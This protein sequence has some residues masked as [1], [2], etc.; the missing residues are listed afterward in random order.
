MTAAGATLALPDHL[1]ATFGQRHSP[2]ADFAARWRTVVEEQSRTL[3]EVKSI[4]RPRDLMA[5]LA[6]RG[7]DWPELLSAYE[8][9]KTKQRAIWAEAETLQSTVDNL[10]ARLTTVKRDIVK[11]EQAKGD[12][13]RTTTPWTSAADEIRAEF[14]RRITELLSIRRDL[15][16][17]ISTTKAN[18]LSLER[19]PESAM[20]RVEIERIETAAGMARLSLVRDAVLTCSGLAHTEHRPAAWWLPMVDSTGQWFNQVARTTQVYLQP[21]MSEPT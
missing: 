11:T 1:A 6:K 8:S 16:E 18:R 21:L 3:A 17:N 20:I 19:S 15:I 12:H 14:D 10:Y 2:A 5:Y 13:F 7:G 4:T 9:A